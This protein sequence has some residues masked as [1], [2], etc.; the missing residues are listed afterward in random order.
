MPQ[1]ITLTTD[2]TAPDGTRRRV[3]TRVVCPTAHEVRAAIAAGTY[4]DGML[5]AE[6][7]DEDGNVVDLIS[8]F[9]SFDL[10][11]PPPAPGGTP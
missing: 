9:G 2:L 4:R 7:L 5:L 6:A 11:T 10:G 8:P 1:T 3:V